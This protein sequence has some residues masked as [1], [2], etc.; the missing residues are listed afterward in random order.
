MYFFYEIAIFVIWIVIFCAQCTYLTFISITLKLSFEDM[1]K[2]LLFFRIY[3]HTFYVS[4]HFYYSISLSIS[5][6]RKYVFFMSLLEASRW[7]LFF[8][9]FVIISFYFLISMVYSSFCISNLCF[10]FLFVCMDICLKIETNW[11]STHK[12]S[13]TSPSTSLND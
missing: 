8:L 12:L 2:Q 3:C 1:K 13:F 7:L 6:V 10:L 5:S 11:T 4:D 9:T